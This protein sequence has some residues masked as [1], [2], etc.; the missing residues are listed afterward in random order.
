MRM[1]DLANFLLRPDIDLCF[2]LHPNQLA[3]PG[4]KPP[5]EWSYWWNWAADIS[6]NQ[7]NSKWLLLWLYLISGYGDSRKLCK[8]E[9]TVA[10]ES[11]PAQLRSM[12][13]SARNMSLPRKQISIT[14]LKSG[15]IPGMSPKKSHEVQ[16]MTTYISTLLSDPRN[17][18]IRHVVDI[19]AGQ[20]YLSRALRDDLGLHVLAL[21]W[22]EVQSKGAAR[23]ENLKKSASKNISHTLAESKGSLTYQTTNITSSTALIQSID[24]WIERYSEEVQD[25]NEETEIPILFVAL[26][27]CGSLTLDIIRALTAS[28]HSDSLPK[29]P[30]TPQAAVIVGCCYNLLR[31]DDCT[32]QALK[33]PKIRLT[34]N[35]LQLAAQTPTEWDNNIRE[36]TLSIR[37]VAWRAL[38][39]GILTKGYYSRENKDHVD[40]D[41]QTTSPPQH[42]RLGRL[43]DAVYE[44]WSRFLEISEEKLTGQKRDTGDGVTAQLDR[45]MESR[46]EVFHTIRCFLGPVVESL[47]L[48]DRVRWIR[49]SL[50]GTGMKAELVNLFDQGSGSGRNVAVVITS[51]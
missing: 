12:I 7:S 46:L 14:P 25:V 1:E 16:H 32:L 42:K 51:D 9:E 2:T 19:G 26:H 27:A 44:D 18:R 33:V 23:R 28:L 8:V 17:K 5:S 6:P 13:D 24:S 36:T 40:D 11:I 15:T 10:F 45:V 20:A 4:F 30:W 43:N 39:E 34:P 22:S 38:L 35:H 21:D 37:K 41:D 47:I 48:L 29:R 50:E 3:K 31:E 49:N